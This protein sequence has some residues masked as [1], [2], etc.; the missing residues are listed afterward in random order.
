MQ[1]GGV[2]TIERMCY[3]LNET[4]LSLGKPADV[5]TSCLMFSPVPVYRV[6]AELVAE[7]VIELVAELVEAAEA[8]WLSSSKPGGCG[9]GIE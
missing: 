1:P 2:V 6:V 5:Q 4:I 7:P 3:N 9:K 8:R